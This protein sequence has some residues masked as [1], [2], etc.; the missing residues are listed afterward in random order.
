MRLSVI[1]IVIFYIECWVSVCKLV[2]QR[3]LLLYR[4]RRSVIKKDFLRFHGW[5]IV[6]QAEKNVTHKFILRREEPSSFMLMNYNEI[7]QLRR[8][9]IAQRPD[10][11]FLRRV[12][13]KFQ[14]EHTKEV[15]DGHHRA[16]RIKLSKI[17]TW[18]KV[19]METSKFHILYSANKTWLFISVSHS[20]VCLDDENI[21][22][23][24][25]RLSTVC[26][27]AEEVLGCATDRTMSNNETRPK[28][29]KKLSWRIVN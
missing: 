11:T 4:K 21:N 1:K 28:K 6:E 19:D 25:W 16:M 15:D 26:G 17:S 14:R 20:R 24:R 18:R 23:Q 8:I 13:G 22:K 29:Y 9:F 7:T 10:S 12:W 27:D 3:E 2:G 5:N